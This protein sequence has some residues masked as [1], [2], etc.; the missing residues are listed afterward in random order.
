MM[1]LSS[2]FP[3]LSIVILDTRHFNI[4]NY[5]KLLDIQTKKT[6]KGMKLGAAQRL[7]SRD[8]GLQRHGL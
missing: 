7:P 8:M 5:Y 1:I 2:E 4:L 6:K 3:F